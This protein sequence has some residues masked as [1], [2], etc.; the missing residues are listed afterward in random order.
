MVLVSNGIGLLIATT[1]L[2]LKVPPSIQ[3]QDSQSQANSWRGFELSS[4]IL[5]S[6]KFLQVSVLHSICSK[7]RVLGAIR[8]CLGQ[9]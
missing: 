5:Y 1:F 6:A 7:L 2:P 3:T 9:Q 8:K 4:L